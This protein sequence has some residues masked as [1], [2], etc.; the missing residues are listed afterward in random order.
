[1]KG[2]AA[3][4]LDF[5]VNSSASSDL[6]KATELVSSIAPSKNAVI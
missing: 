3:E 1:M 4:E 2:R 5:D 6:E